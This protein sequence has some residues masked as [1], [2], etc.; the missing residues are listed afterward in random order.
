M[1]KKNDIGYVY[2]FTNESFREGW[3]KIGKTQNINQRLT[4]LDNTSCPLPFDV[5]AT[6]K[7]SRYDDAEDFVHDFISHFNQSLRIRPNREYFKVEPEDALD[8]LYKV[9]KLMNEPDSEIIVYDEKGK[10][11]AKQLEKKHSKHGI[12]NDESETVVEQKQAKGSATEQ[13]TWL[14][15]SNIKYFNLKACYKEQ[16]Q[17]FWQ[18]KSN[19]KTVKEGD[20]GYIYSSSPDKAIIYSFVVV[21]AS[22]AYSTIMDAEDKYSKVGK[23][24]EWGNQGGSF[25]QLKLSEVKN[26]RKLTLD[27]LLNNGLNGAPQ[28]AIILSNDKY[29]NLLAFIE[30]NAVYNDS[31]IVSK[32]YLDDSSYCFC[33][34]KT[35]PAYLNYLN[36]D[37]TKEVMSQIGM[38]GNISEIVDI[39]ELEKLK[40]EVKKVEKLHRYHNTHSCALSQYIK[41]IRAGLSY[42][43]MKKDAELV[44][45]KIIRNKHKC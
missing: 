32:N 42:E 15:S 2:I 23:N 3:V 20:R 30:L 11:Y 1:A 29:R 18:V 12:V 9:K 36:S 43:H 16:G 4:Q 41:Y 31:N 22:L 10:K 40:Q 27:D 6:L 34:L 21:K 19:F 7:T 13:T 17:V 28:N 37:L 5:Y 25:A 33:E 35:L 8:I 24:V 14:L 44:R 26:R 38:Q 45:K 39:A